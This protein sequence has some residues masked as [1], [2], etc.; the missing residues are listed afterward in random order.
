AR[1]AGAAQSSCSTGIVRGPVSRAPTTV[2]SASGSVR[3]RVG[4]RPDAAAERYTPGGGGAGWSGVGGLVG[5]APVVGVGG[6]GV[7]GVGVR[8][9][10]S[11]ERG[12][13]RG[14]RRTGGALQGDCR[15]PLVLLPFS[16][17]L[18][19]ACTRPAS[20]T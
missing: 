13:V 8:G 16:F 4:G 18:S 2:D 7:G 17:A 11:S 12:S 10:A 15:A 20:H 6:V 1:P 5:A 19:A 9:A 3:G 14:V